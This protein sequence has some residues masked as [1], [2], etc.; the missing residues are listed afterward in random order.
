LRSGA[1]VFAGV[2]LIVASCSNLSPDT[3]LP[4]V[5]TALANCP[6]ASESVRVHAALFGC[7]G[8]ADVITRVGVLIDARGRVADAWFTTQ[9]EKGGTEHDA[10]VLKALRG[11]EYTP[12]RDCEGTPVA[13]VS[14]MTFVAEDSAAA[15]RLL[16]IES[17]EMP[18]NNEMQLTRSAPAR[19]RGPRS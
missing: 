8:G 15:E 2:V 7:P 11:W 16:A 19:S 13:S 17:R 1:P 14:M 5:A 6:L 9:S 4:R 10:C 18:H 3:E 12:A